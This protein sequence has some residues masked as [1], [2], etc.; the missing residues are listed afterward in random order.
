[1]LIVRQRTR[2]THG[3]AAQGPSPGRQN[4]NQCE[5]LCTAAGRGYFAKC[6]D[7]CSFSLQMNSMSSVST[8]MR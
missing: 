4:G 3:D 7:D 5:G 1:M 8:M 2:E 6:S